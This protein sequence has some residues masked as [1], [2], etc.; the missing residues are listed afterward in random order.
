MLRRNLSTLALLLG[1]TASANAAPE[2]PAKLYE[3][4]SPSFVAVKYTWDFELRRQELTGPGVVVSED[5]LIM[6]PIGVFNM[7][8]PDAQM[9]D[10]KIIIPSQDHDADEVEAEFVGRDERTNVAFLRPRAEAAKPAPKTL[11]DENKAAAD[12]LDSEKKSAADKKAAEK[13]SGGDGDDAVKADTK[14]DA[15]PEAKPSEAKSKSVS[16]PRKWTPIKFEDA[17][18]TV[19]EPLWSVG[20]LPEAASYKTYLMEARVATTLRG[21]TPQVLVSGGLCGV[22]AVVFNAEGKAVGF[23]NQQSGQ[24]VFLNDGPNALMA[25]NNPP[26]FFTPSSDF[27]RWKSVVRERV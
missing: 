27:A 6:T 12:K 20:V 4:V 13:K 24:G 2:A 21:E 8:I 17:K 23:V 7:I 9:K 18:F 3:R 10:F 26:K 14:A 1:L 15:K 5:G 19:G 25:I 11:G 16:K 22:G